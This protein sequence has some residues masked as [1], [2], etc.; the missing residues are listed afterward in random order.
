MNK[1]PKRIISYIFTFFGRKYLPWLRLVCKKWAN[2]IKER[3]CDSCRIIA[4]TEIITVGLLFELEKYVPLKSPKLL[5]FVCYKKFSPY[6]IQQLELLRHF[7]VDQDPTGIYFDLI[8]DIQTIHWLEQNGK[9]FHSKI[10]LFRKLF[11][12][13]TIHHNNVEVINWL[14]DQKI[15]FSMALDINMSKEDIDKLKIDDNYK[16]YLYVR[17]GYWD[18]QTFPSNVMKYKLFAHALAKQDLVLTKYIYDLFPDIAITIY[19]YY[20]VRGNLDIIEFLVSCPRQNLTIDYTPTK[21]IMP[22]L[23]EFIRRGLFKPKS[24]NYIRAISHQQLDFVLFLEWYCQPD[25]DVLDE[26]A[27]YCTKNRIYFN[28]SDDY[29]ILD[30][31]LSKNLKFSEEFIDYLC[32]HG[33]QTVLEFLLQHNFTLTSNAYISALSHADYSVFDKLFEAGV[34]V[35]CRIIWFCK[36]RGSPKINAWMKAHF[37]IHSL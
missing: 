23:R 19:N 24:K 11:S 4:E 27:K 12:K 34:K 37:D 9:S 13:N 15:N 2:L 7:G 6:K 36:Y 3:R 32:T 26:V 22:Y 5:N 21:Y 8:P 17:N 28:I 16:F 35:T 18:G 20:I 29:S 30:W 25:Q 14:L 1:L 33:N 10:R 31:A